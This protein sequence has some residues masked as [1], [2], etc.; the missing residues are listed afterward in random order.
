MYESVDGAITAIVVVDSWRIAPSLVAVASVHAAIVVQPKTLALPTVHTWPHV[1]P[2]DMLQGVILPV[3]IRVPRRLVV[4]WYVGEP[5]R[6]YVTIYPIGLRA[7]VCEAHLVQWS[8][9]SLRVAH[10]DL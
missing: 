1:A 5:Y 4:A 10:I 3:A 6:C 8:R 9:Q 7:R 2:R